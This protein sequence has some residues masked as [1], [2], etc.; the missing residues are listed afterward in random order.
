MTVAKMKSMDQIGALKTE[1]MY[2][3]ELIV[4]VRLQENLRRNDFSVKRS[5]VQ[6]QYQHSEN[7]QNRSISAL[8]KLGNKFY[9]V[10]IFSFLKTIF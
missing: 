1:Y 8:D 5:C 9:L 6:E 4:N 10:V 3:L 2:S 7:I